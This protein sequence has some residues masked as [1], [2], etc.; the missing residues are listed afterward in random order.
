MRPL[1]PEKAGAFCQRL[2][3][4]PSLPSESAGTHSKTS[5]G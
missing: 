1:S 4:P 3:D 5:F 2:V